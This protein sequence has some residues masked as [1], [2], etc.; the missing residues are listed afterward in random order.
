MGSSNRSLLNKSN[1][2]AAILMAGS[3][4]MP[5]TPASASTANSGL[6]TNV[7][8]GGQFFFYQNGSHTGLPSCSQSG[9]RWVIDTSTAIGQIMAANVMT[10]YASGRP[11]IVVGTGN[12][13]LDGW[14]ET[15]SYISY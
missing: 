1:A 15:V 3:V 8:V 11:I 5:A 14:D 9:G 13:N 10:A 12:C 6:V 4:L 7:L 2:L